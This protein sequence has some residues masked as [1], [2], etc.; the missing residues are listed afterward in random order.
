M[1]E[2]EYLQCPLCGW[3][4]ALKY[5]IEQRDTGAFRVVTFDKV[6]VNKVKM[7]QLYELGSLGRGRGTMREIESQKSMELNQEY[8]QQ[9]IKQ[10]KQILQILEIP[11][12]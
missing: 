9:I 1:S 11:E 5:G 2:V 10:C 3:R 12:R 8:R 7:W 4:K 6:D